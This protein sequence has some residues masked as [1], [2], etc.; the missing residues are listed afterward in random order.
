MADDQGCLESVKANNIANTGAYVGIIKRNI[1]NTLHDR[2][3][4]LVHIPILEIQPNDYDS[5]VTYMKKNANTNIT[6]MADFNPEQERKKVKIQLWLS[7]TQDT[8]YQYILNFKNFIKNQS[9]KVAFKPR[10][11]LHSQTNRKQ[12]IGCYSSGKYC[13]PDL[14]F[15]GKPEGSK[16]VG[17]SLRQLIIAANDQ[18]KWFDYVN[19]FSQKCLRTWSLNLWLQQNSE[20]CS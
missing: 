15:E 20:L 11:V 14:E 12:Y 4:N 9:D 6:L 16:I 18:S 5:I 7:P 17:Q 2:Q 13:P 10:F 1:N 19:Y 8:A 3:I